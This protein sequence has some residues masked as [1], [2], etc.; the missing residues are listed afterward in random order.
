[1]GKEN[2]NVLNIVCGYY[3]MKREHE[4]RKAELEE[5][6]KEFYSAMDGFFTDNGGVDAVFNAKSKSGNVKLV[7]KKVVKTKHVWNADKIEKQLGKTAGEVVSKHYTVSD[8]PGL[9]EYLKTCGVDPKIFKQHI[10]VEKVVDEPTLDRLYETGEVTLDQ[11]G[12]CCDII[13]NDPYYTVK[14][15]KENGGG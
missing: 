10:T 12:G 4:Q 15:V 7:V 13:Q 14:V 9:I 8:M 11:L 3:D 5:K 1:M 2:E 6:K